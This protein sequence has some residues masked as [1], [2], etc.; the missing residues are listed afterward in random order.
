MEF[1]SYFWIAA[2]ILFAIIEVAT[3]GL[4][5]IWFAVGSLS[6]CIVSLFVPTLT[7]LQIIVFLAVSFLLLIVTRPIIKK[8]IIKKQIPTNADMI[9]G[10]QAVVEE[11][12]TST[13]TGRVKAN[14]LSWLAS[15]V[16]DLNPGDVCVVQEIKGVTL[17]VTAIKKSGAL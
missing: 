13:N 16:T 1:A 7:W 3:V 6:G 10:G 2:I 11:A 9:I 4:V 17:I 15:S 12:I 8:Y 14:G 5:S